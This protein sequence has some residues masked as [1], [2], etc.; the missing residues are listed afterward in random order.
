MPQTAT[1]RI[2]QQRVAI[3]MTRDKEKEYFTS[4]SYLYFLMWGM[5]FKNK[6]SKT[7]F[8]TYQCSYMYLIQNTVSKFFIYHRKKNCLGKCDLFLSLSL[9]DVALFPHPF[10][11]HPVL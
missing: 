1:F 8:S 6:A 10:H 2:I 9:K 4:K 7:Y 5:F 3:F 11:F